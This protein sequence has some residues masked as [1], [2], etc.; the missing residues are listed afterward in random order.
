VNVHVKPRELRET[1]NVKSRAI[2]SQSTDIAGS[3]TMA[4]AS[5]IQESPK[6]GAVVYYLWLSV[7]GNC[8]IVWKIF[9]SQ[10]IVL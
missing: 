2:R 8:A 9:S 6:R 4:I 1:P 3:T 7:T 10:E 5:R